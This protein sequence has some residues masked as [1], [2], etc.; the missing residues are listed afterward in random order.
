M[1][2][3]AAASPPSAGLSV[4]RVSVVSRSAAIDAAFCKAARVTFAGSIT[5]AAT[6]SS[7]SPVAALNP[8]FPPA[9]STFCTTTAPSWPALCAI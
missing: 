1:A 3:A 9:V 2:A 8:L 5:P 6:K 4:I 7:Y